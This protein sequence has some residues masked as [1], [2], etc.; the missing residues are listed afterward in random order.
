MFLTRIFRTARIPPPWQDSVPI[1]SELFGI[2][3]LEEHARSLAADQPVAAKNVGGPGLSNR[4]RDNA[5]FLL[6]ASQVLALNDGGRRELTPAAEWLV[7]N[8]H[9]VAVQIREIGV[10]LPPGY[11]RQLPKLA[12]GPFKGLPRV[13]GAMW[14]LVAHTDSDIE[15][16]TLRRYLIAYQDVQP[17]TIGELWAVPITLRIVLIE[18]LRRVAAIIVSNGASRD[19]ANELADRL[20]GFGGHTASPW[21]EVMGSLRPI[22]SPNA[23]G[24]QLAHRLRGRDPKGEPALAWLDDQ[25]ARRGLQ[26]EA[27]V[28][29]ELQE[30]SAFS[31]TIRNII[32][33]LRTVAALDWSEV[34][35]AL[36]PV[37]L[38]LSRSTTFRGMDFPTRN[39]YRNAIEHLARGARLDET[40]I[41]G[42]AVA[43]AEEEDRTSPS[44]DR[45][46]D[47][48]YSLIAG[49]RR[50]FEQSIGFRLSLGAWIGRICRDLGLIW[51]GGCVV[52][53]AALLLLAPLWALS[54][55]AVSGAWLL[56]LG[57]LGIVPASDA[58]VAC[59]NRFSTW[60]FG[61]SPL[62][63]RD[64]RGGIPASL[65]T[66]VV[67]PTLLTSPGSVAELV[68]R[69]EVHHL[70]SSDNALHFALLS[71][72]TDSPAERA[73]G[74]EALLAA[75][76][77][78]I[79]QLN[80]RYGP[81]TGGDRFI[82]LHR[83][84]VWNAG[85]ASWMGWERKRGK[86]HE[87]NRLLRGAT[88]TSFLPHRPVPE[89]VRYIVT[90]DSD[91]RLPRDAVRRLV[92]K[93][94]HPL[95]APR[96]DL[97]SGRVVE[98]YAVLQ[99]RITPSLPMGQYS[100][101]FQRVF[102]SLDGIDPYAGAVSDVYQDLLGEGSFAGKGIY[103]IDAFEAALTGRVP[104]STLLSHDLFEGV[105]A[106]AGLASDIEVVE[107]FPVG[108]TV[109]AMRQHRWARGDWQLLPWIMPGGGKLPAIGR[110]K[111]LDNLRRTL[112]APAF[113]LA[114]AAGWLLP[115]GPALGWT[116]FVIATL[117]LPA[118]IPLLGVIT[119]RRRWVT[120]RSHLDVVGLGLRHAAVLTALVV[121]FIA[122]QA[123]LM[124]DAVL[125][126]LVRLLSR[127]RLLQWLTAAQAGAVPN[128]SLAGHYRKMAGAPVVGLLMAGLAM[129]AHQWVCLLVAPFATLWIA[130]P[131]IA[132]WA[133]RCSGVQPMPIAADL[134]ALRQ[135]A[136]RTWRF[137]ETFVTPA[138]NMLPP[139]NFQEDPMP[140]LARRTSPTNIGLYLLCT[141]NAY[142]FGW[143]G[144]TDA[145][146]RL[147]ATMATLARLAQ[148]RGHF[149]NWYATQDLRPLEPRYVSTV[150]SGNLAGHLIALA[151]A[152]RS[153]GRLP[154]SAASDLTGLI[155]TIGLVLEELAQLPATIA[156]QRALAPM[157]EA[158]LRDLADRI[159]RPPGH[160]STL[161]DRLSALTPSLQ[162][163]TKL[164]RDL[165]ATYEDGAAADVVFWTKAI[166]EAVASLRRDLDQAEGALNPRLA[167]LEQAARGMALAMDFGFLRR[168]E[169]KLL[170]IGYLVAEGTLDAN[171]YDLL[172]SEARLACFIA[173]AKGD[174]P[175]REWFRLGRTM[176]PVDDGAALVS[177]S[178]SMFEYLM[179][180]LVMRA[181]DGSLLS[182]TN[183]LAVR[184]QIEFGKSRGI[185]W[186]A[187]E[188]AYNVRDLE[189]TY[190]YSN[191]GVPDLGLKS[192]L[193]DEFVVAPY[194][195]ALAAMVDPHQAVKNL[196]RL[197]ADGARGRY[198][199]FEAL[200]YTPGRVPEGTT[201]AVVRA[202]MAHHQGM[203]IVAIADATL[204]GIMRTRFHADPLIQATELLLQERA[205]QNV[206][207]VRVLPAKHKPVVRARDI[208]STGGR[209]FGDAHTASPRTHLL[210]NGPYALMLTAAGSGYSRWQDIAVTR[211]REDSTLDDWGSYIYLR[212]VES[213]R[214]WSAG[215]QPVGA[216]PDAYS[217]V[218]NEDH[219]EFSRRDGTLITKMD[220]LLSAEEKGEVRRITMSNYG[221]VAR[222]ID[223]TSYAELAL[224]PQ[225]TDVAHPAFAKLFVETEYL[226]D[227]GAL[228]ATRRRRTPEEPEIWAAHLAVADGIPQVETDRARFIGRGRDLRDPAAMDDDQALSG[229]VGTVLD[230]IFSIRR[231]ITV[232]PGATA[233]V[234]FWTLVASSREEIV[235]CVD[236]HRDVATFDRA[237]MMAWTQAQVQLHHLSITPAQ[238]DVF[239][240]L[241]GHLLFAGPALRS[242][243]ERIR[244]GSGTQSGLWSQSISGDLPILLLRIDDVSDL[245]VAR[246]VLLAHEY[247][248]L[249]RFAV[250]LVIINDHPPSY[251]QELQGA[252]EALIR[253]QRNMDEKPSITLL[254]A[255]LV[256]KQTRDLL[257]AVARVVI[258]G[259]RGRLSEQLDRAEQTT[260]ASQAPEPSKPSRP[261]VA[262][263][264]PTLPLEL[265][266]GLGGFAEEGREYVAI[267]GPGQTTPAPW[268]NVIANPGFGFQ[269]A[270]EGSGFTWSGNSRENQITPWSNDPV[271]NRTGEAFYLHDTATGALWCPTAAP[272]RDPSA[273]YVARH[274]HGYS[275]FDHTA[276]GIATSLLQFVAPEDPVKVSRLRLRN[277]TRAPRSISVC[278]YVEWVLGASRP[279]TAAFLQTEIDGETGA[280]FARNPWSADLG[281]QVAFM[282]L[283]G[284]QTSWTGD[285]RE[286]LGRNGS[287]GA[288]RGA[289]GALSGTVGA[290]LDPCGA[291][292]TMIE[293]PPGGEVELVLVLGA[294]MG[295]N[296]ARALVARYRTIDLDTVLAAIRSQWNTVLG[297]IVVQTPDRSMDIMLNGWLLYQTLGSRIWARAGFYQASGAY[298]FRDQ[299][300][301][302]LALCAA[303]PDL[304]RQHLLRAAGRQFVEGDVQH[305]W[306][307]ES[308]RGVRT[309]ISDDC[310]WLAYTVAHYV[311]A[312]NDTAVLDEPINFLAGPVLNAD[313]HDRFFLPDTHVSIG[314]LYE[315]CARALDHSLALGS[316]GLPLMGTG[317]WND[318]MNRIGEAGRG[319]SVWLGWFLH[320]ALTAFIPLAEAR[321]DT[322]R[323][324]AW[325]AHA[326]ALPEAL[327]RCWDGDWY[328]RAYHDDGS[329]L[330]S[331]T[332]AQCMIDSIAQSWSV[333]SGVAPPDHAMRAMA[334]LD[335]HLVRADERLLLVLTPP[336]DRPTV[337]PGYIAGYPPGIRE[338]GGQYSHAAMWAVLAFTALGDGDKAGALFA[339]LNPINHSTTRADA[340]RYKV[341]P[342]AVVADI[343]STAPHVGR[344]GWSW[345]TG[346]AGWMQRVGVE[347][348]LGIR[349]R[350]ASLYIDPCIPQAWPGFTAT[351][352]WHSTRYRI[353]VEN[354]AHVAKGVRSLTL[355]GTTLREGSAVPLIEDGR[356]HTVRVTLGATVTEQAA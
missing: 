217:V 241:A 57:C 335:R 36:C 212:D 251:A 214:V 44:G 209:H 351:I 282:D 113:V 239:Q 352:T 234:A 155:D 342:Y 160:P 202:F 225:A 297:A 207:N 73:E 25:V 274:G 159:G 144:M 18:N 336:F 299:L 331:H 288:P 185:P 30:Q 11:Y 272:C 31:A 54:T 130:S 118:L 56:L 304:V 323:A 269:V 261:L 319:E 105:F 201:V 119:T 280:L 236:R 4:L 229:T 100:S 281:G 292:R 69:L 189:Y 329:P 157:L 277:L 271:S 191:F 252:L 29:D 102:S 356:L 136:R 174:V 3:R 242:A 68:A 2:E 184:R 61:A 231:R 64:L 84:R 301:D 20:L 128:L 334:S 289:V 14:S 196:G 142:D 294:A 260:L 203:S 187:S 333:I 13:F 218:F 332:D 163:A 8:Y 259:D 99:P 186:G 125:R 47:P 257:A 268:V 151:N 192:G 140:V 316:H 249:K 210:C 206:T 253:A 101:I 298:G 133:S 1:R 183:R 12:D 127:R 146:D 115:F 175:A 224:A 267:L 330:G 293:L 222:T 132:W 255:D 39:L 211:W 254:R 324:A 35:E 27:V 205:P 327:E 90:L 262:A 350:G 131:A 129:A 285:R 103:D 164:A 182:R 60:A 62:P 179:P 312:T 215:A 19:L 96:I 72:W 264:A 32:T 110:W 139:D 232:A 45:Q 85:E 200:D 276:Q 296:A 308:G 228:L 243:P 88:D 123:V 48:G 94:A 287:L 121:T 55:L 86:L 58:A 161:A 173:I 199:F 220:V 176:T 67:V 92:G 177:W 23:F 17:L 42:R 349:I 328:L 245:G 77:D 70:A 98:G 52:G 74:D 213:G 303:R 148:F 290:G 107:D 170:S 24:V 311:G 111:M 302:G 21:S 314:S 16:E 193:D 22:S 93:M 219:A 91:T 273:T 138:D 291:L 278:A 112:S 197:A 154:K 204:N 143:T 355:D 50:S 166:G 194:A 153:W 240:R 33:S 310:A 34:F 198:G 270:A 80:H 307:P 226:A 162:T 114:L 135:L 51:Y 265:F 337:D 109:A 248:R 317:D 181:P 81:A 37:D 66:L 116:A 120:W 87:L 279:A 9:L 223:I 172:A 237:A 168:E 75:A 180:S 53:L 305:W 71:D 354:P 258:A 233:R 63:E 275:R 141:V 126:T 171:C 250:D 5:A 284:K 208:A 83:R 340:E 149:F 247:F 147:E 122:H 318:G 59:V 43:R 346:S 244:D 76:A 256:P 152:C 156:A 145:V 344:G 79:A 97:A 315:H 230:P 188:S 216:A 320:A 325:R 15:P 353:M 190:Q 178:G 49:G 106:R 26:V 313:E 326:V 347:G 321:S 235:A 117:A 6:S 295:G 266:N 246:Q 306:L 227:S 221:P 41:A 46:C 341:E 339:M 104:D 38:V 82:L 309:R 195:T 10:D 124:G 158:S 322:V 169:R 286:F 165:A 238:A 345:Y 348:I 343:Y 95:N 338:N 78:G 108:Y 263:P 7:D 300:Q 167:A 134:R 40:E 150:D 283:G 65:R 89:G 137:F 28:H